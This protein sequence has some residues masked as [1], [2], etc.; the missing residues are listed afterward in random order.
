MSRTR[1]HAPVL[2]TGFKAGTNPDRMHQAIVA[3]G[4]AGLGLDEMALLGLDLCR[5]QLNTVANRV[6]Y[7]G[8]AHKAGKGKNSSQ[9]LRWFARLEDAQAWL[10]APNTP[11]VRPDVPRPAQRGRND[12][13]M[14]EVLSKR[15]AQ[16]QREAE[17]RASNRSAGEPIITAAT[18]H[19]VLPAPPAHRWVVSGPV[20]GGFK[21]AGIGGYSEP[22]SGWAAAALGARA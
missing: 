20:V 2:R 3:A 8:L 19:V 9:F 12:V 6:T 7:A 16:E 1:I 11:S 10:L 14:S 21:S 13:A 17:L 22:A 5:Q 18:R 4:A 15:R